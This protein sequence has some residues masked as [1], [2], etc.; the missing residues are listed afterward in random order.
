MNSAGLLHP[1]EPAVLYEIRKRGILL[2]RTQSLPDELLS[3]WLVRTAW[4]NGQ[5]LERFWRKTLLIDKNIWHWDIDRGSLAQLVTR[6]AEV[7][8]T[9]L[10]RAMATTL[11]GYEGILYKKCPAFGIWPWILPIGRKVNS[12]SLHGQQYCPLCL[13]EDESP[14]FR[15]KWRLAF[16]VACLTHGI[17]LRD[18]CPICKSPVNFHESEV[19]RW[20]IQETTPLT[21]CPYCEG[22]YREVSRK[23]PTS[24]A[25]P[26][27]IKIQ[28]D[29]Y[30]L[31][32]SNAQS[33]Q[34]ATIFFGRLRKIILSTSEELHKKSKPRAF[35]EKLRILSRIK[36]I[37]RISSIIDKT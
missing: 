31:I 9:P 8:E 32:Y 19:G 37:T 10:E 23:Y 21:F 26:L 20:C 14:Y 24:K 17:I 7:T 6:L 22:D 29:I 34:A 11:R 13:A 2:V 25:H 36:I 16:S 1:T 5:Y 15:K 28:S 18:A 30:K 4:S 27:A 35:F 12:W 33:K 3:S